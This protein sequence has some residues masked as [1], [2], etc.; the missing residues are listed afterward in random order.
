VQFCVA[1]QSAIHQLAPRVGRP[2]LRVARRARIRTVL[3]DQPVIGASKIRVNV[4]PA[5]KQADVNAAF[6]EVQYPGRDCWRMLPETRGFGAG[7][8]YGGGTANSISIE[9]AR[10]GGLPS[11]YNLKTV[12]VWLSLGPHLGLELLHSIGDFLL[13]EQPLLA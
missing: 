3:A 13:V 10:T 8:F 6:A 12:S 5:Q 1:S 2:R 9:M 11:E 4:S 7:E